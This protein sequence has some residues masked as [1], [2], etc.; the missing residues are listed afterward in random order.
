[1]ARGQ[2]R[3][4]RKTLRRKRK[5]IMRKV[6]TMVDKKLAKNTELRFL[7]TNQTASAIDTTG[8]FSSLTLVGQ[9]DHDDQRQGDKLTPKNLKIN[10]NFVCGDS[11]NI[12][13]CLI[14]RWKQLN[15]AV[16][17][18]QAD[19]MELTGAAGALAPISHYN[20]DKRSAYQV[21]HDKTIYLN[22]VDKPQVKHNVYLNLKKYPKIKYLA[23][24]TNGYDH[25]YIGFISDSGAA[26]HPSVNFTARFNFVDS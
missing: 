3:R 23:T 24:T 6:A 10:M 15:S 1:M 20:H 11:T 7:D 4:K 26:T 22:G 14:L 21:L 19:V 16:A 2:F 12:V 25:I 8:F 13:R 18:I 17:P 5:T 9:G